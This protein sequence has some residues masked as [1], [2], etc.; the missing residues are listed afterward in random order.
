VRGYLAGAACA[1]LLWGC[2]NGGN[3]PPPDGAGGGDSG[4]TD[5]GPGTDAL[6][7]GT[8]AGTDGGS[9]A[10]WMIPAGCGDATIA[11]ATLGFAPV[12]PPAPAIPGGGV[13]AT[14][15]LVEPTRLTF[16][17]DDTGAAY[18]F[19]TAGPTL[20]GAFTVGEAV[21]VRATVDPV[22]QL[23]THVVESGGVTRAAAIF[24]FGSVLPAPNASST[25]TGL[26]LA[27]GTTCPF[28]DARSTCGRA[29]LDV[30]RRAIDATGAAGTL[31][32]WAGD[33][34]LRDGFIVTVV[35]ALLFPAYASGGCALP[36]S[37]YLGVTFLA[38]P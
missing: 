36:G 26:A 3:P 24:L 34:G 2:G 28:A 5:A 1:L 8:D 23:A 25:G 17:R 30:E 21:T 9:D 13:A 27:Y 12:S 33:Q 31:T 14:V 7:P 19:R 38:T 32:L 6:V 20:V 15:S 16:T 10:G 4:G 37:A 29:P 11:L 35:D 18:F 22:T